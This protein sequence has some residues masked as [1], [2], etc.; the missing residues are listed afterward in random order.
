MSNVSGK[1]R[2]D[3]VSVR[4]RER[5]KRERERERKRERERER[6]RERD[7]FP[8]RMFNMHV[9]DLQMEILSSECFHSD[10]NMFIYVNE[11]GTLSKRY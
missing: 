5:G 10:I 7:V 11:M 8:L 2:K 9:W 1:D 3:K 4:E 6:E